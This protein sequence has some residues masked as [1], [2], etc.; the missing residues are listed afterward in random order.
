[1]NCKRHINLELGRAQSS[2]YGIA[3]Q[4]NTTHIL[5]AT[6]LYTKGAYA[7]IVFSRKQTLTIYL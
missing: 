6:W 7:D 3:I 4:K 1:M 2:F 5:E